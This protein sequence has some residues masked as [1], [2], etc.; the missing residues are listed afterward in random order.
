MPWILF[1]LGAAERLAFLIGSQDRA[2]PFSIFYEGDAEA[3]HDYAQSILAGQRFDS[4]IPF[5]PPFFPLVLAGLHALLGSP[6]PNELL[7]ALLGIASAAVPV[8]LYLVVRDLIGRG[9][10][11]AAGLLAAFSFGLDAISTSATSEGLYLVLLLVSLFLARAPAGDG[12]RAGLARAAILGAIGGLAA[13]TRAEG[14]GAAILIMVVWLA[15]DLRARPRRAIAL[16]TGAAWAAG[17]LIILL[18]WTIRNAVTLSQWNDGPGRAMGTRIPT[19]VPITAYGPL[20]FALANGDSAN[21]E[22]QRKLLTSKSNLAILDLKDPQHRHYFLNGTAEGLRWIANHPTRF[23]GLVGRKLDITSRALDLGW[24]P[25]NAPPG[26][27]GLR[28]PVDMFAPDA[29][30]LR[31]IQMVVACAGIWLLLRNRRRKAAILFAAPIAASAIAATLFF[32]YVRLGILT[33]PLVFAFEGTALA[34]IAARLPERARR[35]IHRREVRWSLIALA[36]AVLIF[37]AVQKRDYRASGTAD[38]PGG[39]LNRDAEIRI[40]PIR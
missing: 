36:A 37:A 8:L 13:L 34:W 17:L 30:G 2:W 33:L 20:N 1:L 38:R 24:T 25:W 18:P 32:G 4:G 21:G 26:R 22:F 16:R 5:H 7:R 9:P 23:A 6:V 39:T 19:F 12:R 35:S 27:T 11:I 3:F 40:S 31:F 29:T 10:A 15:E 28:R 14:A